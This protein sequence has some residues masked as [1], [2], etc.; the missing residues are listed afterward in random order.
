MI[1]NS[2]T[3]KREAMYWL[4]WLME[5]GFAAH[6]SNYGIHIFFDSGVYNIN[7]WPTTSRLNI[8]NSETLELQTFRGLEDIEAVFIK[9]STGESIGF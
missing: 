7:F 8:K 9:L 6:S 1:K 5:L 2:C 3:K 4:A